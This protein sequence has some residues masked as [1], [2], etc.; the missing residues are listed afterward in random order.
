ME[1]VYF[2]IEFDTCISRILFIVGLCILFQTMRISWLPLGTRPLLGH[3]EVVQVLQRRIPLQVL[4]R[5]RV[6]VY[7]WHIDWRLDYRT[8]SRWT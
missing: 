1:N 5:N 6:G 8:C 7:D 2:K 4:T 3:E